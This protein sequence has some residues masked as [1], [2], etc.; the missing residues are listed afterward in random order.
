MCLWSESSGRAALAPVACCLT[1]QILAAHWVELFSKTWPRPQ[2]L[3]WTVRR[4]LLVISCS[5]AI[6]AYSHGA[7]GPVAWRQ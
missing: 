1:T 4:Y 6:S 3:L 2:N 7:V 5:P